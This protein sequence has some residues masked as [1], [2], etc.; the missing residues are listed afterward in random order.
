MD[1]NEDLQILEIETLKLKVEDLEN[2]LKVE[3]YYKYEDMK[4]VVYTVER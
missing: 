1:E 3:R 2:Q 4:Q